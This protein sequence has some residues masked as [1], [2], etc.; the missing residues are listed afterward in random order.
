MNEPTAQ[1]PA[2]SRWLALAQSLLEL[3]TA[4]LLETLPLKFVRDFAAARPN[5]K[6]TQ[7]AAGNLCVDYAPATAT[8]APL[9][10]VA[11]LD[12]PGFHV[13]KIDGAIV[14]LAFQGWVQIQHAIIGSRVH[15]F[16]RGNPQRIGEGELIEV[17]AEE[18]RLKTAKAKIT[19]G[20]AAPDGFAMWAFPGFSIENGLIVTRCCDDLLGSAVALCVLDEIAKLA[21]P[22]I[23]LTGLFTRAEE[24]GFLGA[25]EAIRLGTL[26]KNACVLSLETSR[27]FANAP[28]GGG[29]I[30]RVGDKE[31][32]F[33]TGL[34][35]ALTT[36]A[37]QRAERDKS[38]KFQRKLMDGGTCEATPFCA[39]G[40]RA[41]GMALPLG[42]YHNQAFDAAGKP[43]IGPETVN[44]DDFRC[45]IELL[46]ELAQHPELLDDSHDKIPERLTELSKKAEEL[47]MRDDKFK[48]SF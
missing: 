43:C 5:L 16:E 10:L 34:T 41:S 9:V 14:E 20:R 46:I 26:P 25:F 29:A 32:I 22:D 21:P 27:A 42:N 11:H 35:H 3:P 7:D 48:L 39:Y 2:L 24:L 37:K 4:P 1:F 33:D 17:S 28:Q 45:Q 36:A 19:S 6:L 47:L 40:F 15:F 8:R 38:F 12:H 44:V 13:T 31:S 30:V 23:A 18:G